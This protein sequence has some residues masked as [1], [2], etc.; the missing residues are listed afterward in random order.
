MIMPRIMEEF[1]IPSDPSLRFVPVGMPRSFRS[2]AMAIVPSPLNARLKI[3]FT[4]GAC[5]GLT[6]KLPF[7]RSY[8]YGALEYLKV[9]FWN[10]FCTAHLLLLDMDC[11]SSSAM[12]EKS[13]R[14]NS[15]SMLLVSIFSFW[16]MM[17]TPRD[18]RVL[19]I[20]RQS[21]VS[22][23]K[24]EIDLVKTRSIR[25]ALQSAINRCSSGLDSVLVPV[26]PASQ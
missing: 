20:S 16:K 12:D 8:P 17:P 21:E 22:R 9:P 10:R 3:S 14:R 6:M 23:E 19:T 11:D 25:W 2:L 7:T 24:R 13:V 4:M 5:S 1:H 18:V 26:T 15:E